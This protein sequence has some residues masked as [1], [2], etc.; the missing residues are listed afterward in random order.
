MRTQYCINAVEKIASV[1]IIGTTEQQK[2]LLIF[3]AIINQA[4]GIWSIPKFVFEFVII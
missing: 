2:V 4:Q 3:N 1:Y